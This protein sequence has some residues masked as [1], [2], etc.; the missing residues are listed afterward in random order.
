MA[1]VN[2]QSQAICP[3]HNPSNHSEGS[4]LHDGFFVAF[5]IG[6]SEV[7]CLCFTF[8]CFLGCKKFGK[9]RMKREDVESKTQW[10]RSESI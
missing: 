7:I 1:M 4:G 5:V 2:V 10:I 6:K 9:A 8:M 3:V